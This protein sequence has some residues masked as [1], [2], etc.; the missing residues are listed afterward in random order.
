MASI[1]VKDKSGKK[2]GKHDLS[3]TLTT[4][5]A[6]HT[7]IHRSVVAEEANKRQG[8]QSAKTRSET[9]GGGRKPYKQK[10]T[11]NARQG[12]IRAPHYAHGGMALAVKPRD[13]SKKINI[14][15][16]RAAILSA[17]AM[18]VE[19]DNVTV[20]DGI[21]FAEPKTKDATAFLNALGL[22]EARRVLVILPEYDEVALKCFRNLGNVVVRT[23][24]ATVKRGEE[25]P[26]TQAFSARDVLV[27]HKIVVAKDAL[28]KI[29]EVWG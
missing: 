16:R 10:K 20:V 9:R 19:A 24:P 21:K 3:A 5:S 2:V 7:T 1:E 12:T 11:G 29:E 18:H 15:E 27:A 6:S 23:A 25:G 13:Y 8:T 17:F 14:R 28:A 4:I 22:G 26:K